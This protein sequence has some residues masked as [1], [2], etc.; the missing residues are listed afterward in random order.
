MP[1]LAELKEVQRG[2]GPSFT[3]LQSPFVFFPF[4]LS[5][6]PLHPS[7][8]PETYS[9]HASQP[10]F[11]SPLLLSFYPSSPRSQDWLA[12]QQYRQALCHVLFE[13]LSVPS[14]LFVSSTEALL[15][16]SGES[17]GIMVDVGDAETRVM[18]IYEGCVPSP[19]FLSVLSL[20]LVTPS[21]RIPSPS[22][23]PLPLSPPSPR[24]PS[25]SFPCPPLLLPLCLSI[26]LFASSGYLASDAPHSS[27]HFSPLPSPLTD[28]SVVQTFTL[29]PTPRPTHPPTHPPTRTTPP[30]LTLLHPPPADMSSRRR[31]RHQ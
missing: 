18:P 12:P 14:V 24:T 11:P 2:R 15:Y 20:L 1:R 27:H 23:L 16:T 28:P 9:L 5:P 31:T 13:Q 7:P 22:F 19:Y 6:V 29:A 26:S 30:V 3:F 25:V 10:T 4:L 21:S 8:I 17:T